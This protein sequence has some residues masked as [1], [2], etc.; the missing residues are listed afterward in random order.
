MCA[1]IADQNGNDASVYKHN[2]F[3]ASGCA[4]VTSFCHANFQLLSVSTCLST[5]STLVNSSFSTDFFVRF[6]LDFSYTS[7]KIACK[8][9]IFS[10]NYGMEERIQF[11]THRNCCSSG[12]LV[13]I[14]I[15]W[16]PCALW[17]SKRTPSLE[18]TLPHHSTNFEANWHFSGWRYNFYSMQ[19]G[20]N[21][22]YSS[23][24]RPPISRT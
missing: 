10:E 12:T 8:G 19:Y 3:V 5:H 21:I 23:T 24:T 14:A 13:G 17:G 11:N 1:S 6:P 7:S 15:S 9:S 18:I 22:P 16:K 2:L 4:N 20:R